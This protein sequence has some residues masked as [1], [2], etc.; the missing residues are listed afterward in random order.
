M[1]DLIDKVH[2]FPVFID[3]IRFKIDDSQEDEK[4]MNLAKSCKCYFH[5]I[6]S[7]DSLSEVLEVLAIKREITSD[8]MALKG[9]LE[10]PKENQPF[11]ENIAEN[12]IPIDQ[13]EMCSICSKKGDINMVQCPSCLSLVHK[14]CYALWAKKTQIGIPYIFR[15]HQCYY[16]LKLDKEFVLTTQMGSETLE[17]K[18]KVKKVGFQKFLEDYELI[19]KPEVKHIQDPLGVVVLKSETMPIPQK[20]KVQ[21]KPNVVEARHNNLKVFICPNCGRVVTSTYF[22][23]NRKIYSFFETKL[24]S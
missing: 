7:L 21:E 14:K 24:N 4:I 5:A 22:K 15:C 2:T 8:S 17:K 18:A 10:I 6:N 12:L 23:N 3:V 16:L 13:E 11:L 19:L 20:V 9:Y 1:Q